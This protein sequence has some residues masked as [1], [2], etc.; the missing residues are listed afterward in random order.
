MRAW[1]SLVVKGDFGVDL[2]K[3]M[4]DQLKHRFAGKATET[5]AE[6][7]Q[8]HR[9]KLPGIDYLREIHQAL[10]DIFESRRISKMV[11]V[12]LLWNDGPGGV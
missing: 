4:L 12:W 3:V 6:R 11:R 2:P 10:L 8:R 9:R 7:R 1:E 5:A